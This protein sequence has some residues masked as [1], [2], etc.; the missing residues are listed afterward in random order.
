MLADTVVV[1]SNI[2]H[3]GKET[4]NPSIMRKTTN[5]FFSTNPSSCNKSNPYII[6]MD[7]FSGYLFEKGLSVKAASLIF[8]FIFIRF[9]VVLEEVIW[10]VWSKGS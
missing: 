1:P 6:G 9:W 2:E 4:S 7:S 8:N 5:Q 10:L 3:V